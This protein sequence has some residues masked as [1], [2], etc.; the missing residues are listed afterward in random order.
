[1]NWYKKKKEFLFERDTDVAITIKND[2]NTIK[3]ILK[4][5]G[6]V[7]EW[8]MHGSACNNKWSA[9]LGNKET[10]FS[11]SLSFSFHSSVL[12]MLPHSFPLRLRK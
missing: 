7:I 10:N 6:V 12:I 1:M 3:R 2:N 8:I 4:K 9:G 11:L 5:R